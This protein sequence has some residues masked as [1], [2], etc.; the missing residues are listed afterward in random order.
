[1]SFYINKLYLS[2]MFR[3]LPPSFPVTGNLT[4][5]PVLALAQVLASA[6]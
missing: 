5:T 1:M 4:S 6:A 2:D 3:F